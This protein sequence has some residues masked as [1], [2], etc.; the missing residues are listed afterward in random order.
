MGVSFSFLSLCLS[1]STSSMVSL[2]FAQ[3]IPCRFVAIVALASGGP[4]HISV[5]YAYQCPVKQM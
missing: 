1:L 5:V 2:L 4:A 3:S